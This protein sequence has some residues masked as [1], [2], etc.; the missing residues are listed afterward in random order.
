MQLDDALDSRTQ[1]YALSDELFDGGDLSA[2]SRLAP[3]V[4]DLCACSLVVLLRDHF[5]R[6]LE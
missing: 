6:S 1:F 2:G 4:V 5:L 3:V